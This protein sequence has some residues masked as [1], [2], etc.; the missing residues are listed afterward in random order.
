MQFPLNEIV[1]LQATADYWTKIS[2]RC[3]SEKAQKGKDVL[4]F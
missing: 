1:Q 4:K 2:I 3:F